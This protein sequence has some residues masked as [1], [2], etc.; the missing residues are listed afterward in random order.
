MKNLIKPKDDAEANIIKSVLEEHGIVVKLRSFHDT[1]YDGLY[2]AQYGWGVIRVSESD[3]DKAQKILKEWYNASPNELPWGDGKPVEILPEKSSIHKNSSSSIKSLALALSVILNFFFICL[4]FAPLETY[5]PSKIF[6]K[7]GELIAIFNYNSSSEFPLEVTE[8]SKEGKKLST[9]ID[10]DENGRYEKSIQFFS[11]QEKEMIYYDTNQ[12]GVY[13]SLT[14]K[15]KNGILIKAYDKD[16]NMIFEITEVIDQKGQIMATIH[17]KDQNT[18][19]DEIQYFSG[20]GVKKV[21]PIT[22]YD[23]LLNRIFK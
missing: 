11:N 13:E 5:Q 20:D 19:E 7:D 4:Y 12:N 10:A 18:F 17:D 6:D 15:Y 2:Q 14:E 23:I 21:I 9:A 16:E 8:Y 3:Y 1:A 22:T